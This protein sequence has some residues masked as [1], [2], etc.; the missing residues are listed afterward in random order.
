[1]NRGRV[2][3]ITLWGLGHMKPASGTWGSMPPVLLAVGLWLAGCGP[4]DAPILYH[5]ALAMVIV[6]ASAACIAQG[7]A[8]ESRFGTKDPGPAV[9]DEAAG[10][11]LPLIALPLW[12]LASPA[13]AAW[14]F[15]FAFL[16]FRVMDIL[17][18]WP[19][20]RLQA[21]PAGWGILADDLAAGLYA[22]AVV[23]LVSRVLV[24]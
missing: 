9:A 18:P 19:A 21:L 2:D 4:I 6:L 3:A 23:Q 10:Q 1:M 16:S 13:A 24:V 15:I 17:K 8:A 5:A 7:D 14:T 11:C 20:H 22:L 12:S